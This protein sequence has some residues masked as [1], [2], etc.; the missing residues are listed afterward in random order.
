MQTAAEYREEASNY[1]RQSEGCTAIRRLRFLEMAQACLRLADQVD[2]LEGNP[3]TNG[4]AG[5]WEYTGL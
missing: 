2:F 5:P 3:P 4:H 1:V